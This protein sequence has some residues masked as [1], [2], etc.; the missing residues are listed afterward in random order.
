MLSPTCT[1]TAAGRRQRL[2]FL[3]MRWQGLWAVQGQGVPCS[4]R[5]LRDLPPEGCIPNTGHAAFSSCPA[6]SQQRMGA[7]C[8]R[9]VAG[10]PPAC[11]GDQDPSSAW[12]GVPQD[13][14]PRTPQH[15]L[16]VLG[17]ALVAAK[18]TERARRRAFAI[19]QHP[20]HPLPVGQGSAFG[21]PSL[22]GASRCQSSPQR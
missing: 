18:P 21:A 20:Q 12:R 10:D 16:L 19:G 22:Q 9:K 11:R 6:S 5:Q 1:Q 4:Q 7:P 3:P 13:G 15:P 17:R 14:N 8:A 2:S